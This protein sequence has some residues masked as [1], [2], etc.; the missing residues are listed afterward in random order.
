MIVN[1]EW[2]YVS[3]IVQFGLRDMKSFSSADCTHPEKT[4]TIIRTAVRETCVPLHHA[5]LIKVPPG[6]PRTSQPMVSRSF[7]GALNCTGCTL[8]HERQF[9]AVRPGAIDRPGRSSILE[10]KNF[11]SSGA[12]LPEAFSENFKRDKFGSVYLFGVIVFYNWAINL[13]MQ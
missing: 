12:F 9:L 1:W 6:T 10:Q 2:P 5:G 7:S 3:F 8:F 13:H 11:G 4:T